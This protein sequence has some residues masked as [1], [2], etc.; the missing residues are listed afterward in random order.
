MI[1]RRFTARV[2]GHIDV[3]MPNIAH[4]LVAG[5]S[6]RTSLV[7]ARQFASVGE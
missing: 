7:S 1:G 2:V 3:S 4:R 6:D 5:S